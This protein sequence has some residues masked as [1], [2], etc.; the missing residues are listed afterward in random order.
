MVK[1]ARSV[2]ATAGV[3]SIQLLGQP[4]AAASAP[5]SATRAAAACDRVVDSRHPEEIVRGQ[6]DQYITV[7]MR[8]N[9][10]QQ[11]TYMRVTNSK[12]LGRSGC[13]ARFNVDVLS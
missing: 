9:T 1:I 13:G 7:Q 8:V 6:P 2:L 11:Y 5:T 10:R 3:A 4:A 12:A